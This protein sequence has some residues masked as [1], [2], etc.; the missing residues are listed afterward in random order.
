MKL[1][2]SFDML[3]F[4]MATSEQPLTIHSYARMLPAEIEVNDGH[5]ALEASSHRHYSKDTHTLG[6]DISPYLPYVESDIFP[7]LCRTVE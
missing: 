1:A 4:A 2:P 7:P 5:S 3:P 6:Y